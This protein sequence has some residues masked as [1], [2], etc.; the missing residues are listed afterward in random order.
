MMKKERSEVRV[1]FVSPE[2]MWNLRERG[3][4]NDR[5]GKVEDGVSAEI[6]LRPK[7]NIV[8]EK[9]MVCDH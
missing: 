3:C 4:G 9:I 5:D 8:V 6:D 1:V 2:T 7:W